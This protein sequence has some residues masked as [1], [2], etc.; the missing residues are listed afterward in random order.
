M[1]F[2]V[3]SR[4]TQYSNSS[5]VCLMTFHLNLTDLDMPGEIKHTPPYIA[6]IYQTDLWKSV[7]KTQKHSDI[8]VQSLIQG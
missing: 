7:Y 3:V 4:E 1:T 5:E 6:E 2:V 8:H